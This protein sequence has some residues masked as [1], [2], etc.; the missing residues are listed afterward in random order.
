MRAWLEAWLNARWYPHYE[1]SERSASVLVRSF[2]LTILLTPIA[3]IYGR[4]VAAR[5][6]RA[7]RRAEDPNT[8]VLAA[9]KESQNLL[10]PTVVV[11]NLTAG[12]SGKTPLVAALVAQLMKKNLRVGI[13]AR[14]YGAKAPSYPRVVTAYSTP[15][16]CGD[17]ALDLA[18]QTGA[19]VIVAPDRPQACRWLHELFDCQLVVSDDGLQHYA[20]ARQLELLVINAQRGLGNQHLIPRGPLREPLDRLAEV[21]MVILMQEAALGAQGETAVQQLVQ[22]LH[23]HATKVPVIR[24]TLQTSALVNLA[25]G[26][27]VE[28]ADATRVFGR[29]TRW[30]AVSSIANPESFHRDLRALRVEFVAGVFADH[31]VYRSTDLLP[32]VGSGLVTTSKDAVK[33][34]VLMARDPRLREL[35]VWV[36]ERAI[37]LDQDAQQ[38][39]DELLATV[40]DH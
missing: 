34:Q 27:R 26:A 28:C 8:Q 30:V 25:T 29:A 14:G 33:I 20:M 11:G 22:V 3:F 38:S 7:R 16:E 18:V 4:A 24:C 23:T 15:S 36:L 17:E 37:R 12:G 21:D 35:E 2:L 6:Q 5:R 10:A 40:V 19:P 32:Y 1:D 39:L 9:R 13:V 31:H